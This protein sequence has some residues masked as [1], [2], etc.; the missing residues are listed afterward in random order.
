[1]ANTNKEFSEGSQTGQQVQGLDLI[2]TKIYFD[3]ISF[4]IV[5]A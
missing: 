1:M 4:F 5:L 3:L 2:Q